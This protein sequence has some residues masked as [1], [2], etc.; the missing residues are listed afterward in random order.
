[1]SLALTITAEELE[2]LIVA[3]QYHYG[4]DFT[5][6]SRASFQRQILRCMTKAGISASTDMLKKILRDKLFFDWFLESVTVNVTE[7]FRDPGFY[8]DIRTK[9]LPA[10]AS[11]PII[12]IWHA[13]CST[14]EEVYSMAI[15]LQESGLLNRTRIYA[16]DI[17]PAN[18]A[19]A[20]QGIIPLQAMKEYT[21][22]YMQSGG[23]NQFSSYYT[24]LY[25]HAIIHKELRQNIVFLQHN[26]VTDQVFNEF[27]LICCRNVLIYFNRDLQ[28]RVFR[29][30]ADSLAPLGYLALGLKESL[31]MTD[32]RTQFDTIGPQTKLFRRKT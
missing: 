7:M 2:E 10:L 8:T 27:H 30:F 3:I 31:L 1:M 18:L 29:L 16:T 9:I 17:N 24:A 22:N 13:G 19:K 12:K 5:N 20:R 14:G 25:N 15:M 28:N 32:V 11:Y 23:T 26:L 4:Y 6:Y 21:A